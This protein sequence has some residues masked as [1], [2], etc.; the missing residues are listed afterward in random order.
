MS[1]HTPGCPNDGLIGEQ[2]NCCAEMPPPN[3]TIDWTGGIVLNQSRIQ[4]FLACEEFYQLNYEFAGTGLVQKSKEL[5]LT[6]GSAYHSAIAHYYQHSRDVEGAIKVSADYFATAMSEARLMGEERELWN[7]DKAIVEIMVRN[8]HLK[9]HREALE[10]LAPEVTGLVQLGNS[11]HRLAIRADGLYREYARIGIME[12]KTKGRTPSGLE[13]ARIHTDIQP[14]AYLYAVGKL[15]GMHVEMVKYRWAIK[16]PEYEITRMHLEEIT[17]RTARDMKRFEDEA[18]EVAD[19]IVARRLD[20]KWLHNWGQCTTFGECRMRRLCLHHKEASVVSL[21]G[22]RKPD[23]VN[24][25]ET[26]AV[27]NAELSDRM[28]AVGTEGDDAS[29]G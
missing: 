27:G 17:T 12:Y 19:R 4:N 16:K 20:G 7:R 15:T 22:A 2:Y 3:P 9:Y 26:G 23:Y 13:V 6:T 5:P 10:I 28:K 1:N 18:I 25:A 24:E 8:Y 14:T 29:N 11:P 21:Y